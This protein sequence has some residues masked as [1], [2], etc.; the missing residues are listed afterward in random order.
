[1]HDLDDEYLQSHLE[2]SQCLL[3][4]IDGDIVQAWIT[5][6]KHGL[7]EISLRT[8]RRTHVAAGQTTIQRAPDYIQDQ[9]MIAAT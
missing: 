3:H 9:D 7:E 2:Q 5:L 8:N 1:V 6:D 4:R